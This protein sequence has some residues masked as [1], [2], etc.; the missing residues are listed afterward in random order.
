MTKVY[1]KALDQTIDIDA[2]L[3]NLKVKTEGLLWF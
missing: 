2:L 3:V 1:S